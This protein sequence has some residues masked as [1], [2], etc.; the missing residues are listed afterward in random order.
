ML[1]GSFKDC[2]NSNVSN[3]PQTCLLCT[4]RRENDNIWKVTW[5]IHK[6]NIFR[7]I[8]ANSCA[9]WGLKEYKNC[10]ILTVNDESKSMGYILKSNENVVN[11][12][13]TISGRR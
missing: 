10:T 12:N 9:M 8:L 11:I 6:S 13:G 2:T 3:F 4:Q 5:K 7:V 1:K